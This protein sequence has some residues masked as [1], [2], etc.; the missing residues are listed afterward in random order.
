MITR[1][2]L[3]IRYEKPGI[4]I[5]N[6]DIYYRDFVPVETIV[7]KIAEKSYTDNITLFIS[8]MRH[9]NLDMSME[10][11]RGMYSAIRTAYYEW[12]AKELQKY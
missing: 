9:F 11:D 3:R 2:V 10:A 6:A 4:I 1:G 7:A 5:T 8:S 12:V